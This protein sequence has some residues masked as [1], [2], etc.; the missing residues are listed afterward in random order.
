MRYN[1]FRRAM[2]N[3]LLFC[4][5]DLTAAVNALD[6]EFRNVPVMEP[7]LDWLMNNYTGVMMVHVL[8]VA[9]NALDLF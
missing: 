1:C 6:L 8:P 3:S 4:V 2:F 9:F 7:M 5:C